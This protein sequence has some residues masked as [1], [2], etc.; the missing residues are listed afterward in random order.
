MD[1]LTVE[2]ELTEPYPP[3][4]DGL[5]QT[6]AGMLSPTAV[7]TMGA[8]V[9]IHPVGTGFMRFVRYTPQESVEFERNEDYDWAPEIWGHQGPAYL[10]KMT[11]R[12]IPEPASRVTALESGDVDG[13][14]DTPA[15][16]VLRLQDDPAYT[17]IEA[18]LPGAPRTFFMNTERAPLDDIN[19]RK[20]LL[21]G[22][23]VQQVVQLATFGLQPPATGPF[24]QP[25]LGYSSKVEG[26]YPYDPEL[27]A[28]LLDEAGWIMGPDGIR[29]K[30]GEPLHLIAIGFPVFEALYTAAQSLLRDLGVDMEVRILDA[31]AATEAN[32]RGDG[33]LAMTGVVGSDPL[34]DLPA[35]PLS[36]L[37]RV[38]LLAVAGPRLRP[39][40]GR[41]RGRGGPGEAASD[42]RGH[43]ALHPGQR[44]VD[45][46]AADRAPQLRGF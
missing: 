16:D 12:I 29:V 2:I 3:L 7:E 41:R 28:Q 14:E 10:D 30:D 26:Y 17:L 24:S 34:D 43:P 39:D 32:Q 38:R 6:A 40:V 23:D 1:D 19:V 8:D 18:R 42:V 44:A 37:Q 20:A 36:E 45:P 13:I 5:S 33:H 9:A 25:T 31:G 27:A 15:Q 22:L 11:F 21:H 4:L 35:L 46:H